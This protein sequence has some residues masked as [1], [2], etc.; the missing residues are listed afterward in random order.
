MLEGLMLTLAPA[1]VLA[2]VIGVLAGMLVGALPGLTA[3][4][5]VALLLPLTF[6]LPVDQGLAMLGGLYVAAMLADAIP[7]CLVNI[8]GTPS[9][10][11]TA[12]DGF[13][14][15]QKGEAQKAIVASAFSAMVGTLIGGFTF[16]F[17]TGPLTDV[18]L[19]FGPPEFFWV[20]VFSLT[21]I[22]SIAGDSLLKGVAGGIFGMLIGTIGISATGAISRY[23]FGLPE[24]RAGLNVVAALIGVFAIPQ[25]VAMVAERHRVFTVATYRR[26]PGVASA[27]VK[28]I[29]RRPLNL[30]RSSIIG[31]LV[32]ILPGAGSPVASP[33]AYNE[34]KRWSRHKSEFGKGNMDGV[35]ASEAAGNAA[36]GGAMVPT[37]GLGVPGSAP[38]AVILGS[39]M[40][41]GV[42]PGPQLFQTQPQL[43]YAFAWAIVAAGIVTFILGSLLA[44]G[45]ARM[46]SIPNR[47]LA[48][49]VLFLS[50]AG[51]YAVRNS[52]VDVFL[53]MGL[54]IL[55]YFLSKLGFHPA[56]IG[57]GI[58]LGPIVEPAL[59]QALAVAQAKTVAEVF[60]SGT[61]N[62]VVIVLTIASVAWLLFA[63]RKEGRE[64][65]NFA[66]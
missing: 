13:P 15:T 11:A 21:I 63:N 60:F 16:M 46:V 3:T 22:G 66:D 58:I 52:I 7:A 17:L 31:T 47:L 32:G 6:S 14:M 37:L 36:A 51:S 39:L 50:V 42:R 1:A 19:R 5:G 27:T 40:L 64:R 12:F 59:V 62:I 65:R 48:P 28:E 61:V 4:M 25:V 43:V 2:M 26:A 23:T 33:L 54:G 35:V 20:G 53:M 55:V 9:A 49:I 38:A 34:A 18:A 45:L 8:P 56:P 24:L 57:L 44:G 29:L 41:H 10:M 30:V